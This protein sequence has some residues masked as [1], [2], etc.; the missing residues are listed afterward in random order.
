MLY[1]IINKNNY[2]TI[3][4]KYIYSTNQTTNWD[5]I[6]I[7]TCIIRIFIV[8]HLIY[9]SFLLVNYIFMLDK[10]KNSI[11]KTSSIFLLVS[12]KIFL[13]KPFFLYIF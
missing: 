8:I 3:K 2:K 12:K 5:K 7:F 9:S 6:Y 1:Y 11:F 10:L 4:Y 13:K